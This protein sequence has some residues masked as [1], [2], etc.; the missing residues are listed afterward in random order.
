MRHVTLLGT[1]LW[2]SQS[3]LELA[4]QYVQGAILPDGFFAQ[5]PAPEVRSFVQRFEETFQETPGYIEAIL[6]DS[7]MILFDVI[8]R[9][10]IRFRG[11]IRRALVDE[12]GFAG[13]TGHTRFDENGEAI[14][15]AF[16]LRIKGNEFEEIERR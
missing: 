15:Q 9:P 14:K 10:E 6:Y 8:T 3:L 16:L 4:E 5:S 7:A 12:N 13:V 11:D 1:N 2:H